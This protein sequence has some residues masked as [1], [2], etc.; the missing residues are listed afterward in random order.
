MKMTKDYKK[1]ISYAKDKNGQ[2]HLVEILEGWVKWTIW[3]YKGK[4]KKKG[5]EYSVD[6]CK[7]FAEKIFDVFYN[8]GSDIKELLFW[9][10]NECKDFIRENNIK[11][12]CYYCNLSGDELEPFFQIVDSYRWQRGGSFEIDRK[13]TRM[14]RYLKK[15]EQGGFKLQCE[16]GFKKIEQYFKDNTPKRIDIF[17]HLKEALASNKDY[18]LDLP[19]TYNKD[20]CVFACA[21]CN[22]AKTDAFD[23]K[24]FKPIGEEIGKAIKMI[25]PPKK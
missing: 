23:D 16:K 17:E 25:I 21:W 3:H 5:Y 18:Y 6:D 24:Q 4:G 2:N 10:E 19:C 8:V 11:N 9:S 12:K 1:P 22:D 20:N 7:E 15:E 14:E 13:N